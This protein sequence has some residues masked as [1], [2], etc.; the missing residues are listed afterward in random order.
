MRIKLIIAVFIMFSICIE[1][2][3][4]KFQDYEWGA[5]YSQIK[6]QLIIE[7]KDITP[8]SSDNVLVYTDK[9]LSEECRVELIFTPESKQLS[10]VRI[11]WNNRYIGGDIKKLLIDKYG[12]P[13]QPNV[14]AD[15][16]TWQGDS[17]YEIIELDY[18]YVSTV[19]SYYGGDYQQRYEEETNRI[20]EKE[21]YRF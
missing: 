13:Y 9:I 11:M 20:I 21:S 18:N 2:F 19:L 16:Y 3:A 7:G 17:E 15:K 12:E 1:A 14:L 4:F 8:S 5:G 10:S 6:K